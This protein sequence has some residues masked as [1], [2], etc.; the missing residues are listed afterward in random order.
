MM[1]D[2]SFRCFYE[3]GCTT[4]HLQLLSLADIPKWIECYKFTHPE[5]KSITVK[6]CFN[7]PIPWGFTPGLGGTL[8]F[9]VPQCL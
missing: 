3:N 5:V 9:R 4:N 8:G 7:C 6:V 2:I 1:Y